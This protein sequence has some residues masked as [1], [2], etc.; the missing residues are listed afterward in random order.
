MVFDSKNR[1]RPVS[2][3]NANAVASR[4]QSLDARGGDPPTLV[5]FRMLPEFVSENADFFADCATPLFG[6]GQR[7]GGL[8]Q[9]SAL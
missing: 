3:K 7:S 4:A 9:H 1:K 6:S 2:G 5:L 8:V